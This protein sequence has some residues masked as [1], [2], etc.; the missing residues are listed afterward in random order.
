MH[1]RQK[2]QDWEQSA[3]IA[4]HYLPVKLHYFSGTLLT[5]F[6]HVAIQLGDCYI[7][8]EAGAVVDI[9]KAD[10]TLRRHSAFYGDHHE[11]TLSHPI[12]NPLGLLREWK[13]DKNWDPQNYNLIKHN[14]AHAVIYIAIKLGLLDKSFENHQTQPGLRP[15]AVTKILIEQTQKQLISKREDILLEPSTSIKTKISEQIDNKV[16]ALQIDISLQEIALIPSS[17]EANRL[18]IIK[19]IALKRS[20]PH[21]PLKTLIDEASSLM[22]DASFSVTDLKM[23][24]SRYADEAKE[25]QESLSYITYHLAYQDT[26]LTKISPLLKENKAFIYAL[27]LFFIDI[28]QQKDFHNFNKETEYALACQ[29]IESAETIEKAMDEH[30]NKTHINNIKINFDNVIKKIISNPTH[31]EHHLPELTIYKDQL[32]S[33]V[34]RGT[35]RMSVPSLTQITSYSEEKS[36]PPPTGATTIDKKS[37]DNKPFTTK[38]NFMTSAHLDWLNYHIANIYFWHEFIGKKADV[39]TLQKMLI[40]LYQQSFL[41]QKTMV[42]TIFRDTKSSLFEK[43]WNAA[44]KSNPTLIDTLNTD[45]QH[46]LFIREIGFLLAKTNEFL[47]IDN[48]KLK[49]LILPYAVTLPHQDHEKNK[50]IFNYLKKQIQLFPKSN[51]I[52]LHLQ[53][54]FQQLDYLTA[55]SIINYTT[56]LNE[57]CNEINHAIMILD[58]GL[59]KTE[60]IGMIKIAKNPSL[61]Q[62]MP[63]N[64][65][66][67]RDDSSLIKLQKNDDTF[68]EFPDTPT[69]SFFEL[70][71]RAIIKY[72]LKNI[73]SYLAI[74]KIDQLRQ[75][76]QSIRDRYTQKILL[77]IEKYILDIVSDIEKHFLDLLTCCSLNNYDMD[78]NSFLKLLCEKMQEK[79]LKEKQALTEKKS[80]TLSA[81]LQS[82]H[83]SIKQSPTIQLTIEPSLM[84]FNSTSIVDSKH[85]GSTIS[86]GNKATTTLTNSLHQ[87]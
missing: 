74:N 29:F 83:D 43:T 84:L 61:P 63:A 52:V 11:I 33:I 78:E 25:Q 31:L 49:S 16:A 12:N 50:Y 42:A 87:D 45:T 13:K 44:K 54:N 35:R 7:S 51:K 60:L 53:D 48:K 41:M 5:P 79:L 36:M 65:I 75:L 20:I 57:I 62:V 22:T 64:N 9:F 30:E 80:A 34:Y 73:L 32:T 86:T 21:L 24:N 38:N 18:K 72:D 55:K 4:T 69:L 46:T 40:A 3:F 56:A 68:D 71:A 37:N 6:G 1:V 28:L 14:C 81:L 39:E 77:P 15:Y 17:T 23:E 85:N 59:F 10:K 47:G 70:R 8:Y 2:K 58:L 19:L 27:Y 66:T 67:S 26:I 76:I 82:V